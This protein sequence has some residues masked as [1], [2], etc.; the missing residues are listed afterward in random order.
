MGPDFKFNKASQ[1]L[2]DKRSNLQ[3]IEL[4]IGTLKHALS[5]DGITKTAE[6][7]KEITNKIDKLEKKAEKMRASIEKVEADLSK[8]FGHRIQGF[9]QGSIQAKVGS[10][11]IKPAPI[12]KRLG[13]GAQDSDLT[14]RKESSK[15]GIRRPLDAIRSFL[16]RRIGR[17]KSKMTDMNGD[18]G[19]VPKHNSTDPHEI[20]RRDSSA[21]NPKAER[22]LDEQ[23]HTRMNVQGRGSVTSLKESAQKKEEGRGL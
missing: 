6:V 7:S 1:K 19:I 10:E 13:R 5:N 15:K 23:V 9:I 17:A 4:E 12:I 16:K 8:N 20:L 14:G 11:G 3:K 22:N 21:S 18:P 2:E